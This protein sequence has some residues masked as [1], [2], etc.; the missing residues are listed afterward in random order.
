MLH[1]LNTPD[2]FGQPSKSFNEEQQH[3]MMALVLWYREISYP[4]TRACEKVFLIWE[5]PS[6]F[7]VWSLEMVTIESNS[8][9]ELFLIY[10]V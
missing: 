8:S 4:T 3:H 1:L 10:V 5:S 6:F 2:M 7:N 9:F